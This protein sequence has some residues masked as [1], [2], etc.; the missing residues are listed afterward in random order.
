MNSQAGSSSKVARVAIDVRLYLDVPIESTEEAVIGR[1][2]VAALKRATDTERIRISQLANAAVY[3]VID[4]RAL[5]STDFT[6][7]DISD[8]TGL[9]SGVRVEL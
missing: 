7:C 8:A 9:K 5:K 2:A 3:P 6:I 1:M 4:W